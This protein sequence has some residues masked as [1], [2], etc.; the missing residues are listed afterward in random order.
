MGQ[1]GNCQAELTG[2]YCAQ[3]GQHAHASAR[4]I[5][6]LWNDGWHALTHVDGRIWRSLQLL[7]FKPGELTR[8]Y[9]ANRRASHVPPVRLYL[10]ISVVTFA[11]IGLGF[12]G[13]EAV[14]IDASGT[15]AA[16]TAGP[17][18]NCD[19]NADGGVLNARL[20]RACEKILVDGG[21]SF[22]RLLMD[23]V[24]RAMFL[25][26]P[27]IALLMLLF[28]WRPRR[29]Y[30][31]HFVFLLHTHA[32]LFLWA[33][34]FWGLVAATNGLGVSPLGD[35]LQALWLLLAALYIWWALRRFYM[36]GRALTTL[37]FGA[38]SFVYLFAVIVT[39]VGVSLV[40]ALRL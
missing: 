30:V 28:Y 11:L 38:L 24:P 2:P 9:F 37:K 18:D 40:T 26:L 15:A 34:L 23:S 33:I 25:M 4:S 7:L 36:Q 20:K 12:D 17:S 10:I 1:C 14:K 19:I 3:C 6:A 22:G 32:A 31:E 21:A 16:G 8:L 13:N 35:F 5:S 39:M 27:L 29:L